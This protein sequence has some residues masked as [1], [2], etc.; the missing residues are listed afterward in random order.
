MRLFYAIFL[1]EEVR[2]PLAEAQGQVARYRGWKGVAPHQLH[3]TLLFLG[4]RPEG[5]LEDLLALGHR[6]GRLFPTFPARI[7]G[8]GYFPN[9]GTPRVWFAKAEGEGFAPLAEALRQGV[10]ELLGEEALLA[11]GDKPFKPHITLARRKAPAPRVPPVVFG[12]EWPVAE[13]ALVRSE[14]RP[15]GPIYTL[16]EK[17]PLRGEHGR[18]QE[19]SAG[20]HAE[21]H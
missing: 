18:E 4:E 2:R 20:K 16:L 13:F 5:D 12:L 9:E 3:L 6:L 19:E 7:R 14:L 21:D 8:T 10:A 11:G 17:F 1:P 15:K